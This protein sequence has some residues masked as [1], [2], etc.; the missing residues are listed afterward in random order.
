MDFRISHDVRNNDFEDQLNNFLLEAARNKWPNA[1]ITTLNKTVRAQRDRFLTSLRRGQKVSCAEDIE[2]YFDQQYIRNAFVDSADLIVWDEGKTTLS[3]SV[4]GAGHSIVSD[5]DSS[6]GDFVLDFRFSHDVRNND[7][8]DQLNNF[9]LMAASRRENKNVTTLNA[10]VTDQSKN[11]VKSL[12]DGQRVSSPKGIQRYF[13]QHYIR[14]E[15]L[16]RADMIVWDGEGEGHWH[17]SKLRVR[18]LKQ[19]FRAPADHVVYTRKSLVVNLLYNT[20]INV[21]F[22]IILSLFNCLSARYVIFYLTF[23]LNHKTRHILSTV[24]FLG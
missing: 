18:A 3:S 16:I 4:E 5:T 13:T 11:L 17:W 24:V 7:F 19:L 15:F 9:L 1:N 22:I 8:E 14:D 6:D 23:T 12:R 2:Q 21:S 20:F 10:R